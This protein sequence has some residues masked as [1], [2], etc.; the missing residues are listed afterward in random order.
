MKSYVCNCIDVTSF[1]HMTSFKNKYDFFEFMWSESFHILLMNSYMNSGVPRFQMDSPR[2]QPLAWQ[3]ILNLHSYWNAY[4][5]KFGFDYFQEIPTDSLHYS[6]DQPPLANTRQ[7]T[8]NRLEM[9]YQPTPSSAASHLRPTLPV[10]TEP[11][12]A[13]ARVWVGWAGRLG[14]SRQLTARL[15]QVYRVFLACHRK[16]HALQLQIPA[17]NKIPAN[18]AN[19]SPASFPKING[20]IN[21]IM[22]QMVIN[23]KH[24]L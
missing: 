3:K 14:H 13:W 20:I 12:P 11:C 24:L 7:Y 10:E 4:L 19:I 22:R 5:F 9:N 6:R 17:I 23:A 15:L 8:F 16:K 1:I 21:G 2:D 18:W